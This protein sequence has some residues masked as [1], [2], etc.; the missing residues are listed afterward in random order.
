MRIRGG[1][2]PPSFA[3][4]GHSTQGLVP[5]QKGLS[6]EQSFSPHTWIYCSSAGRRAGLLS[7]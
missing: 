1:H 7:A 6:K 3:R 5:S 2:V 4:L